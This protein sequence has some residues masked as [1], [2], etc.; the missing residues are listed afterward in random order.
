MGD[1]Y[2]GSIDVAWWAW[3]LAVPVLVLAVQAVVRWPALERA[4]KF[5]MLAVWG[6]FT[7]GLVLYV[8]FAIHLPAGS[9]G[10]AMVAAIVGGALSVPWALTC[11]NVWQHTGGRR[12]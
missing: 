3:L 5:L 6:A 9:V 7:P 1:S 2:E 8:I 4:G 12:A 10:K 11:W